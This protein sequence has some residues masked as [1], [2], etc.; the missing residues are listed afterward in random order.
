MFTSACVKCV[1]ASLPV[2]QRCSEFINPLSDKLIL[3]SKTILDFII[4]F[5]VGICLNTMRPRR[6][7]RHFKDGIFECIFLNI[8]VRLRP[9]R[10]GRHFKDGI[11]ECIF[12][13]INVRLSIKISIN[14]V[15]WGPIDN[16]SS[17][18]QIMPTRRQDV[19]W[20]NDV[21]FTDAYMRHSASTSWLSTQPW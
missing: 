6:N 10:N 9:R 2:Y 14:I 15:P 20:I 4:R 5:S 1:Q 17:L 21:Y 16:M 11:F 12:L 7:G 18:G 3:Y 13:N 8:N 19:F